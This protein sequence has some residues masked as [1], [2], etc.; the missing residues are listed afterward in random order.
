[1]TRFLH[2]MSNLRLGTKISVL[3]GILMLPL[4]MMTYLYVAQ[5]QWDV[6]F[7]ERELEGTEYVRSVW[8]AMAHIA[9]SGDQ[10]G[11]DVVK[12]ITEAGH[13]FDETMK[14]AGPVAEF[15]KLS[16][17]TGSPADTLAAGQNA[18]VKIADGSNLTLDPDL[19]SYYLMD[20][21][22][23][24]LPELLNATVALRDASTAY[25]STV[26]HG[27][28]EYGALV[29]AQARF[30]A[31]ADA[32]R[33]DLKSS[34]EGNADGAVSTALRSSA[35][36]IDAKL[37]SF[38]SAVTAVRERAEKQQPSADLKDSLVQ[39]DAALRKMIEVAWSGSFSE[40]ERLLK[41]RVNHMEVGALVKLSAGAS[42]TLLALLVALMLVKSITR[43]L[44]ALGGV[45][46]SFQ[47]SDFDC[48]VPYADAT[49]E[50][51]DMARALRRFQHLGGQQSLTMAAMDGSDT[52][53]MITDPDEKVAFMSGSL[54]K[55][56]M[57][58]EP[59]FRLARR[60]FSVEKM[61]G[62]HTDYYNANANLHRKLISDD[63][64]VRIQ[65]LQVADKI[66]HVN[67]NYVYNN[68]GQK[69]GHTMLWHDITAEV[70]AQQDVAS[71]VEAAARGDFSKRI[72]LDDK[73]GFTREIAGGLNKVSE[74]IGESM[75]DFASVMATVASGDLTRGV[76]APYEGLLKELQDGINDTV[77]RL[78][79][80]VSTIQATASDVS[81]AAQEINGGALD[82]AKRTEAQAAA[83]EETTSTTEALADSV[84][85]S[86]SASRQAE[87][88]SKDAEGVAETGGGIV[89]SAV[90][91]M[92]RIE[93][94][95]Q[96]I[97]DITSVIDEIAFQTNLLALNASVEAAR[98]G[99]AGKGFAVVA[100]EVRTLAQRSSDAA[101]DITALIQTSTEEVSTG[102]KL[103]R[104]AGTVLGQIVEASTRVASTVSEISRASAEQAA[105]IDEM[106]RAVSEMDSMTQQNAALAEQSAASAQALAAR[107][108]NL[109]DLVAT[110]RTQ[111]GSQ[112]GS[113][114]PGHAQGAVTSG[115]RDAEPVRRRA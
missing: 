85:S 27:Y 49:N 102:V 6:S 3:I 95:S 37:V 92:E 57:L 107:I 78:A 18:I 84:R 38:D 66:I 108:E 9:S 4:A 74:L 91:A 81:L 97:S 58:L 105:G 104:E 42:C 98:A 32:L 48:V 56:F 61:F 28:S 8:A 21:V 45:L 20:A 63:G 82:L 11:P 60:D 13:R 16:S 59:T 40:L 51:G 72:P 41:A 39:S 52:M 65:R 64:K 79:D 62:E 68:D 34:F 24:K 86:A 88:L 43:P 71:V 89:R 112:S 22:T 23:N 94:A 12:A 35:D 25:L 15:L 115:R 103:V 113:R 10:V 109:N 106:T 47:R 14:T 36:S 31:A 30:E 5:V 101:K 110:F 69:V 77:A 1:M 100:A 90:Q 50:I 29:R 76:E 70:Q 26:K 44:A 114:R 53:L 96:K 93:T 83:L 99:D 33:G 46:N 55:F 19:D 2:A 54:I 17:A 73:K 67:M 80:T 111:S 75:N 7:S 87:H